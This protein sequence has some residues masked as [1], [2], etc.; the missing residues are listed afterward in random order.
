MIFSDSFVPTAG[1]PETGWEHFPHDADVG[2]RGFG[3]TLAASFEQAALGLVA[4][5]ADLETIHPD[6]EVGIHCAAPNFELLFVDWLNAVIFEMATRNMLFSGFHVQ[7]DDGKPELDGRAMGEVVCV[8]R[9]KPAAEVKGATF[10]E[11]AVARA[12]DGLWHAQ[13]IV[14]V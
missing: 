5:V 9:H 2:V 4:V 7:I 14:D 1:S 11:L 3:P 10:S 6:I 12:D 8:A 13:C